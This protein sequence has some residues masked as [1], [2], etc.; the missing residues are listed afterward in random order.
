M[1]WIGYVEPYGAAGGMVGGVPSTVVPAGP[2]G[3]APG[4][5]MDWGPQYSSSRYRVVPG[6]AGPAGVCVSPRGEVQMLESPAMKL[7]QQQHGF[8]GPQDMAAALMVYPGAEL[9]RSKSG[10]LLRSIRE[11]TMLMHTA[12]TGQVPQQVWIGTTWFRC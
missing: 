7:Q 3:N 8:E 11:G 9:E 1:V 4:H 10:G 5:G 2:V 6:N 12:G